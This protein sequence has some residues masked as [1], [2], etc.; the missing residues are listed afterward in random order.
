M[1]K[2]SAKLCTQLDAIYCIVNKTYEPD[3]AHRLINHV[4]ERLPSFPQDRICLCAPTWGKDLTTEESFKVYDPWMGR[5]GWPCFTWKNRCLIKGEI[6][7]VLNFYMGMKDA[8]EKGYKTVLILESDV[9]LR[10]D[11]EERLLKIFAV[12]EDKPWD[13]ISLS[14]GVGRH[15]DCYTHPYMEQTVASPPQQY[16]F[17]CT[18][19]MIFRTEIFK[20][21]ITTII[22]FR[23]C[24]DWELNFQFLV[25]GGKALWAEP[26]LVEQGTT[27]RRSVSLLP[28]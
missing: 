11:F 24:L 18:D 23:E 26:P 7:L 21:I 27:K 25:H 12:A 10:K 3:R 6:S 19:S 22:P 20:K 9:F 15:A 16:V 13:Y 17:R 1:D 2:K 5:P 4:L 28:S 8:L 14:D